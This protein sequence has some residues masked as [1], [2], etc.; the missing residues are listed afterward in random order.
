MSCGRNF[1]VFLVTK[2]PDDSKLLATDVWSAK[3]AYLADIFQHLNELN[4]QMQGQKENRL[5]ST[6]K[7]KGFQQKVQLWQ[8]H[9]Q[10]GNLEMFP[11]TEKWHEIDT[12]A[13]CEVI[14]THLK[15]LQG[16]LLFYFSSDIA[17][18]LDWV[19]NPYSSASVVG[20]DM[21]WQ[22]QEQFTDLKPDQ[23]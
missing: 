4:T 18:C 11:V 23:G 19:R 7:V 20:D 8:Q 1:Q 2:R 6:D 10:R 13:L 3:L 12:A 5:T 16:K 9:V 21:T 17:Q 14:G 15:T 22:E